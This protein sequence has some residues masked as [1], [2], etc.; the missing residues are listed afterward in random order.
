MEVF[1]G[2]QFRRPQD[3]IEEIII[4]WEE[5][6]PKISSAMQGKVGLPRESVNY[7][8]QYLSRPN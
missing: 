4:N 3:M 2:V 7:V 1:E 6:G 5:L 8:H